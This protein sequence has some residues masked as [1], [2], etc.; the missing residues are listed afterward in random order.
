MSKRFVCVSAV[1]GTVLASTLLGFLPSAS[2]N[3]AP[4]IAATSAVRSA[5]PSAEAAAPARAAVTAPTPAQA[6]AQARSQASANGINNYLSVVD[7][8]T[9]RVLAQA[10]SGTQIASES[11][12][13]LMLASYYLVIAGGYQNQSAGVLSDLSYMIRYSDDGTANSYFSSAAIP[14]IAARYGM[15]STINATDRVGHWG[16][17]RI[18][19]GDMTTFLY[20]AAHDSQVGPWLLP[21]MAQVAPN[22]SDGFNQAFGMNALSGTHGSKQGWGNDMFWSSAGQV[23]NSVGYTDR[24]FVAIL[25]NSYS[26][27]DPARSTATYAARTIAASR[28]AVAA[29]PPPPPPPPAPPR[30]LRSGDFVRLNGSAAVYR[31]AGGAPVYVSSW[32]VYGGQKPVRNLTTAQWHALSGVPADGTFI[33]ASGSNEVYRIA[34]GAPVYVSTWSIYGGAKTTVLVDGLAVR[35]AGLAGFWSHLRALPADGTFVTGSGGGEVY[36]IA[37]GA[38]VYVSTWSAFGGRKP[39]VLIDALTVRNAGHSGRWSHLRPMPVNGTFLTASGTGQV[40]RIVSGAP[41]Y[42]SSWSH[43]GGAKPSTVVDGAAITN[44]GRPGAYSHLRATVPDGTFVVA[45]GSGQ[46]FRIAG[47]APVYVS[48]WN[49]YGGIQPTQLV[50]ADAIRLAG[51]GGQWSHLAAV[52]RDGTYLSVSGSATIYRVAGGAPLYVAGLAPLDGSKATVMIDNQAVAHG[53]QAGQWAHLRFYPKDGTF[54]TGV[55]G[56]RV[57][58]VTGG[59]AT[60]VPSWTPYGGPKPSVHVNQITIDRAGSGGAFNHLK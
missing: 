30:P 48:T 43:F 14:T 24:Y 2:A 40:F 6:V 35:N 60:Y 1:L 41:V 55:P 18:T 23:I 45:T 58:R 32:S 37:G 11:I 50:D 5:S 46:V 57:Y 42:V 19:A 15:N 12:M 29:P 21:V 49:V 52:P 9:G 25:Q 20:R 16:A 31:L 53:G 54:L 13:K 51:S 59:L 3:Q 36:R 47:G 56:G 8:S 17:A 44:A 7:R 38:P 4:S 26:Y 27:P 28:P 39:T 10:G 22:G 34:G 33:T